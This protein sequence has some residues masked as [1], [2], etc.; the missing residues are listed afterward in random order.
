MLSSALDTVAA[1][2]RDFATIDVARH[3]LRRFCM[4]II[5]TSLL[6]CL[7]VSGCKDQ[8]DP[9]GK[10]S[11]ESSP[12]VAK[13]ST[14][15]TAAKP[16]APAGGCPAG[17]TNPGDVGACVKLPE[18]LRPDTS[19][20]PP[21]GSKQAAFGGDGGTWISV[22]VSPVSSSFW[23]KKNDELLAGGG[24]GGK[25]VEKAKVG[26]DGVWGLFDADDGTRKVSAS[27]LRNKTAQ[28]ECHARRDATSTVGPTLP[29]V[30]DVC[31]SITL[32]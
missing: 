31:K 8:K 10:P 26:E 28:V 21:G 5:S 18:G 15:P 16:A 2:N 6:A 24:F 13:P 20:T 3:L 29:A 27:R 30:M 25:L 17:F 4:R 11:P 19:G 23:D 7:L 32:P 22:T 12:P 14:A 1:G 9:A